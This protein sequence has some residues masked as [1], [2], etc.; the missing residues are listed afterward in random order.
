MRKLSVGQKKI[1][2]E[3]LAN[4]AVAWLTIG[5]VT[6]IFGEISFENIAGSILLAMV[7]SGGFLMLAIYL[8]RGIKS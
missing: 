6:P 4:G 3:F 8:M 2:A 7:V 1:L 5:V